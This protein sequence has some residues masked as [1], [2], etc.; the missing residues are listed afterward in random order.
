[1]KSL[2]FLGAALISS[3]AAHGYVDK[4]TIGKYDFRGNGASNDQ[5]NYTDSRVDGLYWVSAVF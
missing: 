3:V 4:I 5:T 2:A 1:M